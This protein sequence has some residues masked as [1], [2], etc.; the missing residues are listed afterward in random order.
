MSW[1]I[2]A[3]HYS[4]NLRFLNVLFVVERSLNMFSFCAEIVF[5]NSCVY[6]Q[7]LFL[8]ILFEFV[9]VFCSFIHFVFF[10]KLYFFGGKSLSL[11]HKLWD[12][13][14]ID[15]CRPWVAFSLDFRKFPHKFP[16][17]LDGICL[18]WISDNYLSRGAP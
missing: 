17:T 9:F 3:A 18:L 1:V 8:T 10:F 4:W 7:Y 6:R 2:F 16:L 15:S 11:N 5:W 14:H 13:V 12:T